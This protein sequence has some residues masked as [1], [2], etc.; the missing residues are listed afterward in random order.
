MTSRNGN[1]VIVTAIIL[2]LLLTTIGGF[3]YF[4]FKLSKPTR[5]PETI[6][7]P[8]QVST[9]EPTKTASGATNT[10][11]IKSIWDVSVD[12][13]SWKTF[14][15]SDLGFSFSYPS[16]WGE[17]KEEIGDVK[18]DRTGDAGKTY[19][20]TFSNINYEYYDGILD[21]LVLGVGQSKDYTAGRGGM[22][23]DFKGYSDKPKGVTSTVW[24]RPENCIIPYSAHLYYGK[25]DF[26][27]P[28]KEISGVRLLMPVVSQ[29]QRK[30]L[31][32]IYNNLPP[33]EKQKFCVWENIDKESL[34]FLQNLERRNLDKL[35]QQMIFVF[36]KIL[37]SSKI[38]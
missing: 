17:V 37:T 14:S 8:P 16:E 23:T 29:N 15:N 26:N 33:E 22:D 36:K 1:I 12:T 31:D 6:A 5:V 24:A 7:T 11:N 2:G 30:K 13:S 20:L 35:S 32:E 38:L 28:G 9:P 4:K 21:N 3:V 25:I 19:S 34:P 10:N 18:T 27:L